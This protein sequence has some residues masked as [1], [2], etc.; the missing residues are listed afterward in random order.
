MRRWGSIEAEAELRPILVVL[1]GGGAG[2]ALPLPLLPM[3]GSVLALVLPSLGWLVA[4]L[5]PSP[6]GY[7]N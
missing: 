5:P 3:A 2:S 7:T 6:R 1:R 4:A